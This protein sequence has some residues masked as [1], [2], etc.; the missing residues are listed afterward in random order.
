MKLGP[1][2]ITLVGA[3]LAM[4]SQAGAQ[5]TCS[6]IPSLPRISGTALSNLI[7]GQTA[8][9]TLGG[10]SWQSFHP[11]GGSLIDYK[12]GPGHPVDPWK[13]MG[14]WSINNDKVQYNYLTGGIFEYEV[15]GNISSATYCGA[16]IIPSIRF[17]AGQG[18]W[19]F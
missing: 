16:S 2:K 8:C 9:A 1:M 14:T 12:K 4:A 10:S 7:V 15:C 5:L 18:A 19:G 11:S 3:F 6:C 13:V 17:L